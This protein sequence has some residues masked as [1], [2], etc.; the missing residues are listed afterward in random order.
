MNRDIYDLPTPCYVVDEKKI[1]ENLSILKDV[2]Q[3]AGCKILL[4]Q[5]AFSMFAVYPLVGE[6]LS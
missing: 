6:Y 3:K 4:A 2:S 5:K 1:I